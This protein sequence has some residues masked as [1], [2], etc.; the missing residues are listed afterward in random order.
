ML[1][2]KIKVYLVGTDFTEEY[3]KEGYDFSDE[4]AQNW[5]D[6]MIDSIKRAYKIGVPMAYGSDVILEIPGKTEQKRSRWII[7]S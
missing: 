2:K 3:L 1:A 6:L 5:V 7:W 4:I